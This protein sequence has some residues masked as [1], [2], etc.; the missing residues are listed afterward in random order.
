[1]GAGHVFVSYTAADRPFADELV[2]ALERRGVRIWYAPR[3]VRPGLDYS[4]QIHKA[5]ETAAAFTV[6][7]SDASNRS[8]FVRAETEMAFSFDRQIFPVRTSQVAP[9]RGMALFLQLRHWTDVFGPSR[10]IAIS[11]LGDE[12]LAL[13]QGPPLGSR[14][15][16]PTLFR[17]RLRRSAG[18]AP[19]EGARR[20]YVPL[21]LVSLGGVAL[22]VALLLAA[23]T[24][25]QANLQA[26]DSAAD[27]ATPVG[28]NAARPNYG[29]LRDDGASYGWQPEP[30]PVP[31]EEFPDNGMN[32]NAAAAFD[33]AI[34]DSTNEVNG[35]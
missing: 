33:M 29:P 22:I 12:L 20:S 2:G 35:M 24:G 10:Q 26:N 9:A 34:P 27:A 15:A 21:L 11:R 17:P 28:A 14:R 23:P 8:K 4:E 3:D 5:I 13:S 19:A 1:M 25:L 31:P 32:A 16:G 18:G 30:A 6:I 7:V